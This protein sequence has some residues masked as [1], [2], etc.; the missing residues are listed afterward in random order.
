MGTELRFGGQQMRAFESTA[1]DRFVDE[2]MAHLRTFAAHRCGALPE[3][4]LYDAVAAGVRRADAHAMRRR[5]PIRLF[6]EA[7]VLLGHEFDS[8]PVHRVITARL[9]GPE[10]EMVRARHMYDE[11]LKY[12]DRVTSPDGSNLRAGLAGLIAAAQGDAIAADPR[13]LAA[14]FPA[15]AEHA[16]EHGL[17]ALAQQATHV[18]RAHGLDSPRAQGVL[19]VTMF[20]LG[21]GALGDWS[22]PTIAAALAGRRDVEARF[23][24]A[25]LAELIRERAAAAGEVPR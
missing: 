3:A 15:K 10:D 12:R 17:R 4:S 7:M 13:V 22:H 6:L 20:A 16:G 11:L 8:D 14:A 1:R 25:A 23:A 5:G 2:M 21:H 24:D 19:L 18:A 9:R